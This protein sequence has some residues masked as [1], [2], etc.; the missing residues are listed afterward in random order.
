MRL[1]GRK[2]QATVSAG[3]VTIRFISQNILDASDVAAIVKE[4]ERALQQHRAQVVILDFTGVRQLSSQ[5]FGQLLHLQKAIQGKKGE[6]RLCAMGGNVLKAFKL[7]RLDKILPLFA[8]EDAAV[9]G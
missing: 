8:S 1:T 3:H 5:M 9:A 7:C 2:T 6:L 4:I